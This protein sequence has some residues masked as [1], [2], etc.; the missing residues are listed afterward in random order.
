MNGETRKLVISDY[1]ERDPYDSLFSE[2]TKH[3]AIYEYDIVTDK[4]DPDDTR[5]PTTTTRK[6]LY[7]HFLLLPDGSIIEIFEEFSVDLNQ[8]SNALE[9]LL[10]SSS[11]SMNKENGQGSDNY[12][13]SSDLSKNII[14]NNHLNKHTEK[15]KFSL[16]QGL[17]NV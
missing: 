11:T 8:H 14:L 3:Y 16:F 13:N 4:Q 12:G 5:T 1:L 10:K 17:E 9:A 15:K 7:R 2:H 6:T